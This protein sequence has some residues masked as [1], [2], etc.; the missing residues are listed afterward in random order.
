[1]P[2]P[3][4]G[5][6]TSSRKLANE[7]TR[8]AAKPRRRTPMVGELL[9]QLDPELAAGIIDASLPSPQLVLEIDE[10][11]R[12]LAAADDDGIFLHLRP[13][14]A[15]LAEANSLAD[16]D[17]RREVMAKL[18]TIMRDEG[19][20]L[21]PYWRSLYRHVRPGVVGGQMNIAYL[22]RLHEFGFAA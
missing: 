20:T 3:R 2:M 8:I 6:M 11:L 21:Q 15:L 1:M 12:R 14:D 7:S 16:A 18:Q 10:A 4:P 22:P 9:N 13:R 17:A 19:V 5:T